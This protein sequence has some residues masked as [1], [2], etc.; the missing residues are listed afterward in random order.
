MN[1]TAAYLWE[2]LY[3][4]EFSVD[5]MADLLTEQYDIDR[6]SALADCHELAKQWEEAGITE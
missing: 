3:G 4:K 5:N 2:Q 1:E 6:E